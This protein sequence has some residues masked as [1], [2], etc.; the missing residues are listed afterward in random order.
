MEAIQMQTET[1]SE[2]TIEAVIIR[3]DGTIKPLGIIAS[4]DNS[5]IET[6]KASGIKGDE[7]GTQKT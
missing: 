3:K 6:K 5:N 2:V 7:N 1:K 4:S